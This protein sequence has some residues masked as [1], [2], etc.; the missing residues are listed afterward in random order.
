MRNELS[1]PVSHPAPAR[2]ERPIQVLVVD[3]HAAVRYGIRRLIDEQPDLRVLADASRTHEVTSDLARW[4]DV[5]VIDYQLGD[6]HGLWLTQRMRQWPS[7][8]AV[9]IYSAFASSVLVA[10][11][12]VAGAS[13][14]LGKTALGEEL[15]VAIRRLF[16]GG[17]YFPAV[18]RSLT[19]ALHARVEPRD[20]AVFSMLMQGVG[21]DEVAERL[22]LT[23][24]ELEAHRESIV[25]AIAPNARRVVLDDS[26]GEALDYERPRRRWGRA[27]TP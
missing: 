12:T 7:P 27:D 18:P 20:Q 22:G 26:P 9:L 5:A 16:H 19:A 17:Q 25:G 1:L 23:A 13:G 6:H 14:L 10:A 11:A 3:D 21:G 24:V 8:P 4:S 15:P 2:V